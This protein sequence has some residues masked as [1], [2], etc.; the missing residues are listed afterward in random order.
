M[1]VACIV[2]HQPVH[3]KKESPPKRSKESEKKIL[4]EGGHHK[5][6]P[7]VEKNVIYENALLPKKEMNRNII[8]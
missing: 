2:L 1:F 4:K 6:N 7:G 3:P 5:R 8:L